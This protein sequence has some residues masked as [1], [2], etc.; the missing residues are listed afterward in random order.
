MNNASL[1]LGGTNWA[2]KDGN[3]LGYSVGDTSG[4]YS[5]QEFTFAR[6]SN[7][8]A[9]RIDRAGLIV[10]GRENVLLQSNQFDTTWSNVLSGSIT[11]GQSGYDGSSDAWLMTKGATDYRRIQQAV[12][13]SGVQTMSVY[14]KANTQDV[15]SILCNAS[16]GDS[17]I[18]FN[19]ATQTWVTNFNTIDFGYESVGNGWYRVYVTFNK[20]INSVNIFVGWNDSDA[21]SIYIQDAQVELGLA[22]SPYIESGAT[23]GTAGVLENTPRLN[24]TTGVANPY[25]LLEPSRTNLL[26]QSEYFAAT[27]WT[28]GQSRDYTLTYTNELNPQG[29]A[30]SYKYKSITSNNQL[31][32]ITN[33]ASGTTITNSIYVKRVSGTGNVLLRNVNN[34]GTSFSLSISDGWK[35]IDVTATS[36]ATTSRIYLN[37]DD[38]NDE[39][40]IW[41]AQQEIGS[42]PTSY[43]PTYSVSATRAAENCSKTNASDVIGQTEGTVYAEFVVNGF[44]NFGTPLCI[45]NGSTNESVW[46]TTFGNGDI[47]AEVFSVTGGGI[48]ASF[49]KSGNTTGQIYKIAIGYAANNF[50]F[51]VNGT[52]VGATD[53]SGSVP[54]GMSRIDYDYGNATNFSKSALEIKQA[55]LYK[56]RLTNAELATLT[57][58]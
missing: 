16:G 10:K 8:S 37:L 15:I 40:L 32:A 18:V 48:Q 57:T 50:A 34:V 17:G 39:V 47:R 42:Y 52:Q 11:G 1:E 46:L 25:L 43:I 51:Y 45:N 41:G 26:T 4:K 28:S 14:A 9:T 30:G 55:A 49:T 53:T 24:Y 20:T 36:L 58:I 31:G 12:S 22:A 27:L 23:N 21:G 35:R 44:T 29:L 2:E 6:G 3:I 38:V 7:L 33:N 54:S 19:L 13:L 5:P 56:E